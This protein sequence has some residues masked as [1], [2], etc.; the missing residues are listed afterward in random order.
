MKRACVTGAGVRLGKAAAL[1]LAQNGYQLILH[2]HS[3]QEPAEDTLKRCREFGVEAELF[4]ADLGQEEEV[5]KLAEFASSRFGGLEL[6]VNNAAIFYPTRRTE[7]MVEHWDR[8]QDLNVKAQFLTSAYCRPAL[9][10]S[11]NG[12]I[13]NIIDIYARYPLKGYLPY[14]VAKAGLEAFTR[15]AA[16]DFAPEIRVNGV[17]PGA[18]MLPAGADPAEEPRLAAEIPLQRIGSAESIADAV[19]YLAEADF[20][21]GQVL[22]VDGGRSV[23]L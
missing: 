12:C 18:A 5:K 19:A 16:L 13:I 22:A 14:C 6:L 15:C 11:G 4:Q 2:Y 8:F 23:N 21:S 1:R 10:A 3:S 17:S 9:A 7:E 20:V